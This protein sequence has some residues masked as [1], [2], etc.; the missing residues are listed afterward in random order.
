MNMWESVIHVGMCSSCAKGV[1]KPM[2]RARLTSVMLEGHSDHTPAMNH[3]LC[4]LVNDSLEEHDQH[5]S[6]TQSVLLS[7][8][9]RSELGTN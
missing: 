6:L 2:V 1:F 5:L 9:N 8:W 3:S 7:S 4:S